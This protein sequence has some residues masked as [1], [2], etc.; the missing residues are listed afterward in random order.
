M[1]S[2]DELVSVLQ[3]VKGG[4]SEQGSKRPATR[5]NGRPQGGL[6]Q[7][8]RIQPLLQKTQYGELTM[9]SLPSL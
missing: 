6:T 3:G 5:R 1:G 9:S 7:S 8:Q 4:I 2:Q